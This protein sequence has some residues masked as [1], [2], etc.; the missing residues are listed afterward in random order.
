MSKYK[1][2]PTGL[3]GPT[4]DTVVIQ[5]ITG[6]VDGLDKAGQRVQVVVTNVHAAALEVQV[7]KIDTEYARI[8]GSLQRTADAAKVIAAG[9]KR[10]EKAAKRN[11]V[12]TIQQLIARVAA[13]EA[14]VARLVNCYPL[15]SI[16]PTPSVTRTVTPTVT[17]TKSRPPTPTPTPSRFPDEFVTSTPSNTPTVTQTPTKT[18]TP[19]V[20]QTPTKTPTPTPSPIGYSP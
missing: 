13:L 10:E 12:E 20:T 15:C 17:P 3:T 6:T 2:R 16:T 9:Q 5:P 11:S 1:N 14:T 4:D 19:T 18:P 8:N 7:A